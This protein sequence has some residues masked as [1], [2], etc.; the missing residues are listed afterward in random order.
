MIS[1]IEPYYTLLAYKTKTYNAMTNP[2]ILHYIKSTSHL[3]R[4]AF[5]HHSTAQ[6]LILNGA[7]QLTNS[8]TLVSQIQSI[9]QQIYMP[10]RLSLATP[11]T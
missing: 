4:K 6:D 11:H 3:E 10:Q 8:E 7:S 2:Q 9:I 1:S 5:L